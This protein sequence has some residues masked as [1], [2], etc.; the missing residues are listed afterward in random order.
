[1]SLT[2]PLLTICSVSGLR[3]QTFS[4]H[5]PGSE[6]FNRHRRSRNLESSPCFGTYWI[7]APHLAQKAL[8]AFSS[9]SA[10]HLKAYDPVRQPPPPAAH[11][12][13]ANHQL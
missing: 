6:F 1:M 8:P 5:F 9:A 7:P 13:F 11:S 3:T 2:G 4:E 12:N 10:S